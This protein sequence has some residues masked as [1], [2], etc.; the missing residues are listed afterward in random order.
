MPTF[1]SFKHTLTLIE[2]YP[3]Y[4]RAT[5]ILVKL[6][7]SW[8]K[9]KIPVIAKNTK[10]IPVFA[11]MQNTIFWRTTLQRS[12]QL[13]IFKVY[14][15]VLSLSLYSNLTW[16]DAWQWRQLGILTLEWRGLALRQFRDK[17]NLKLDAG[18]R[19]WSPLNALRADDSSLWGEDAATAA[20]AETILG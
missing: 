17:P 16:T 20:V 18:D 4:T 9:T 5:K 8:A 2:Q 15:H 19:T 6:N 14:I 10:C 1:P 7:Y 11:A 3:R 12:V 13:L